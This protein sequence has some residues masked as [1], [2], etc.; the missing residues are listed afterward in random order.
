MTDQSMEHSTRS[1]SGAHGWRRCAGKINA[2]V[3][4]PDTAGPEAAAGTM[5]HDYAEIALSQRFHPL[6][7][8]SGETRI[9]N[10]FTVTFSEEMKEHMVRGYEFIMEILRE[11]PDA[12]LFV[13]E[14]VQIE[15]WTLE[16]GG[17]GTSD[18]CIVIPSKR[19][20][21][22]FDWKY[23]MIGVSPIHND[24]L[25]IYALGCWHTVAGDIFGWD[26]EDIRVELYIEQP[27]VPGAG[28]LAV[29]NMSALLAEGDQI[30]IDA[31]ATYNPNAPRTAGEKQ[32]LY[33]KARTS[34]KTLAAYNMSLAQLKFADIEENI[35]WDGIPPILPDPDEWTPEHRAYVWM[36][37]KTFTGWLNAL[38]DAIVRDLEKGADIKLVK[39]IMGNAGDRKWHEK[40]D[41]DARQQAIK[42]IGRSKAV[43]E[44][45][46]TPAALETELKK[47]LGTKLGREVYLDDFAGLV[48]QAEGKP[49]LVPATAP[50]DPIKASISQFDVIEAE[51]EG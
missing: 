51:A 33:C 7:L 48:T 30:R 35:K 10:G 39:T 42:L 47:K 32:C 41:A 15:P 46:I 1:P 24:Q 25:Y 2:E 9:I 34:C 37:R 18:C 19:L 45:T 16:P 50:G 4:L 22:V 27:R 3:G 8:A 21:I 36:H 23:G 26:H 40:R 11:N 38:H 14:R 20:V 29:T 5:F 13:E 12:I 28:G 6:D 43:T 17:F 44:K 31:A 49:K